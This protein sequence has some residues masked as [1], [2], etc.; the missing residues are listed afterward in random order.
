MAAIFLSYTHAD[1]LQADKIQADLEC[2]GHRVWRDQSALQPGRSIPEEVGNALGL[3]E[4]LIVILTQNALQSV[5]MKREVSAFIA[6]DLSRITN[7]IP[8]KFD[9]TLVADF[10]GLL[11]PNLY[12]DM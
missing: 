4:F 10:Y 7:I 12:V 9:D 1:K 11:S 3:A 2:V 5:W 8:L 6:A